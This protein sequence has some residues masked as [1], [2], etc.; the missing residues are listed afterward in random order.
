MYVSIIGLKCSLQYL[1]RVWGTGPIPHSFHL[2]YMHEFHGGYD[3]KDL[4]NTD[5]YKNIMKYLRRNF[6]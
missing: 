3:L 4:Y 2:Q 5:I 6:Q 1:I